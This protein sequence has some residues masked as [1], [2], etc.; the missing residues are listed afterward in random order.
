MNRATSFVMYALVAR[1]LG[2]QEFGQ[3]SLAFSL[4]YMFQVFATAGL[5]VLVIRQV[6]KDRS[7]TSLYFI[8]GCAIVA[9]SSFTSVAALFA[10]VHLM[11]YP[12]STTLVALLLSLG[13]FPTAISAVCEGIF[14]AWE[15][16]HFIAWVNVPANL[17]KIV[18]T[19]LILTRSQ[20]LY[21][22]ILLLLGSFFSVAAAEVWIVL[23]RF[24]ARHASI[25]PA[26]AL[27]T[28]RSGITFLGIDGTLAIEGSVNVLFLSKLATVSEVGFYSA[29]TQVM[30]P[31]FL[32]YQS[33]AQS[34]FPLM[35]R[36]LK[37]GLQNLKGIATQ[38]I[39]ILLTLAL[40]AIAAI[41]FLG[42]WIISVLYKN[43]AF[44]QAVP[45]L[46]I[47]AWTLVLQVF[48]NVL[49]QVLLT[50]HR[51]KITLRIVVVDTLI[52]LLVGWPLIK[53]FGLRGAA[54]TLLV[55]RLAGCIQHYIPVSR[56]LAGIPLGRI[57]WKP[58]FAA[59][60][61]AAYLGMTTNQA[62]TLRVGLALLVYA[63]TLLA[64]TILVSGGP[65]RFREK[66]VL[67]LSQ[68]T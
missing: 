51:E 43:P 25:D 58:M 57:V 1:H 32:V 14:Q 64:L 12:G 50:T 47:V 29:A 9:V 6:A 34:I 42:D 54:L 38:A 23:R 53:V 17:A 63:G 40:P 62:G 52:S 21:A 8:N 22:V 36:T 31:L 20:G 18:A 27:A 5:K 2:A 67:L 46:R 24:P 28:F 3:L 56:L 65:R 61:M 11:H 33:I 10:F 45:A 37:D 4:F 68:K 26:F 44:L 7:Q 55:N 15:K 16:M 30:V 49:G 19:F 35:C 13:L 39:Q 48:S 60:C 41:F 66:Y 59:A